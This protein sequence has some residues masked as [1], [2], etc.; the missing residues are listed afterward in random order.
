[1]VAYSGSGIG[2]CG[3]LAASS[4]PRRL[5]SETEAIHRYD[6]FIWLSSCSTMFVGGMKFEGV[7]LVSCRKIVGGKSILMG[8]FMMLERVQQ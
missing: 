4:E 5:E 7:V 6:Y 2:D 3:G 8:P 1:V